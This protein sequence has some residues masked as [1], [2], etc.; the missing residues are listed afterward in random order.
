MLEEDGREEVLVKNG[1][2]VGLEREGEFYFYDRISLQRIR[3]ADKKICKC[4]LKRRWVKISCFYFSI[5][6][7]NNL[8]CQN[9][10]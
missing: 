6:T 3:A 2:G 1:G 8:I 7:G 4:K 5:L 10:Q 9:T